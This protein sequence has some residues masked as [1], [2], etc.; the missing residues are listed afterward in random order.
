MSAPGFSLYSLVSLARILSARSPVEWAG[1]IRE[2]GVKMDTVMPKYDE[3]LD[4]RVSSVD[5]EIPT[6][7]IVQVRPD[8]WETNTR[9]LSSCP[10]PAFFF[11]FLFFRLA[12][13]SSSP[14]SSRPLPCACRTQMQVCVL[15]V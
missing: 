5:N 10:A 8:G 1:L 2:T 4:F 11:E 15:V 3:V 7:M 14:L 13:S 6:T 12:I 9:V